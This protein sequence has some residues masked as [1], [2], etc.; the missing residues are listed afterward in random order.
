[1]DIA[2]LGTILSVWAHPD[3]ET[4]LCAGIMSA[5][6]DNGQTVVCVTATRGEGGSPDHK[7]YPPEA[8]GKVREAELLACLEILGV[9]GEIDDNG[10]T[11]ASQ[12]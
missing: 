1:M 10:S 2:D 11:D 4:Y 6:V 3:D 8:M 5:A 12:T 7:K 9:R